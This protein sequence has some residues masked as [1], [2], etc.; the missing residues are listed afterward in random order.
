MLLGK[1]GSFEFSE[2]IASPDP[3]TGIKTSVAE[4]E[5]LMA[6]STPLKYYVRI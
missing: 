3:F 5:G 2:M 6:F 4:P 1:L